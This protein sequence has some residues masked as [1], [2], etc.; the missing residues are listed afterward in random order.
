M[1][2]VTTVLLWSVS[3][4]ALYLAVALCQKMNRWSESNL[5]PLSKGG[6]E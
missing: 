6:N 4:V 5:G 1:R 3:N 2:R